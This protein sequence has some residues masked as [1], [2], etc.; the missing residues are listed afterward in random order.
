MN[1]LALLPLTLLAGLAGCTDDDPIDCFGCGLPTN[2][3]GT[4]L[5]EGGELR[6]EH[7]RLLGEPEQTWIQVYQFSGPA[8]S[9]NAPFPSPESNGNGPLGTCVDERDPLTA[10][11]PFK[12]I[13]GAT[14]LDLPKVEITGTS[15]NGALTVLKTTPP[16]QIGNSTFRTYDFTYGGGASKSGPNG[17]FNQLLDA[18]HSTPE[19]RFQLDIGK[20]SPMPYVMPTDYAAPLGIG[21]ADTV[22]IAG[23]SDLALTWDGP[24]ESDSARER[25]FD[26]VVF[27]DPSAA[28][29][30]QFLCFPQLAGSLTIPAAVIDALSPMGYV[31]HVRVNH[32]MEA[33]EASDG[34]LR[35][36]DLVSSMTNIS[37]YAKQ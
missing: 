17:G 9:A 28:Y 1:R 27:A 26:Y 12:P 22:M 18:Y 14:Y 20:G 23:G 36:F 16:N 10:S 29:G 15:L 13:S 3:P 34:A 30:P 6:H 33:R 31:F 35:R 4:A 7:V 32:Y 8:A 5:A 24:P 25:S 2:Q 37:R 11:W 19:A 21:G